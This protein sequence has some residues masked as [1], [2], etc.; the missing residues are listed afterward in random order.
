MSI[1]RGGT[2]LVVLCLAVCAGCTDAQPAAAPP[3]PGSGAATAAPA[4]SPSTASSAGAS[5]PAAS[6]PPTSPAEAST[7]PRPASTLLRPPAKAPG[8][9]ARY[10]FA[11]SR[12]RTVI[13][14]EARAGRKYWVHAACTATGAVPSIGFE[15]VSARPG[16]S[17]DPIVASDVTCDG[18]P[19]SVATTHLRGPLG[20]RFAEHGS[21][22]TSGYVILTTDFE[23]SPS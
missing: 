23:I 22:V 14:G 6:S 21:G 19:T 7:A 13:S 3:A 20:V 16:D 5:S 4:T 10:T 1:I 2:V 11:G 8:E 17:D 9:L 12:A 15:V 18:E